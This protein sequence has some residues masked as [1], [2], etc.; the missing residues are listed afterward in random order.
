MSVTNRFN[1]AVYDRFICVYTCMLHF[2]E[3]DNAS[4]NVCQFTT[5]WI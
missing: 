5:Y 1:A 2:K 4:L 3:Q